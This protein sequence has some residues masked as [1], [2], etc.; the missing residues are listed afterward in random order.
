MRKIEITVQ[1]TQNSVNDQ[2]SVHTLHYYKQLTSVLHMYAVRHSS[3]EISPSEKM[4]SDTFVITIIGRS[5]V[6]VMRILAI[7]LKMTRRKYVFRPNN[8]GH[9]GPRRPSRNATDR[10]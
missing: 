5:Q 9:W 4:E 3:A 7:L 1:I 6:L 8:G 2:N 10:Q